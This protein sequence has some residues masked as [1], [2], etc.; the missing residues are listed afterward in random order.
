M[1]DRQ[2][3]STISRCSRKQIHEHV[4]RACVMLC[5]EPWVH[6]GSTLWFGV[7][8]YKSAKHDVLL[9]C[10]PGTHVDTHSQ[11]PTAQVQ[12][13]LSVCVCVCGEQNSNWQNGGRGRKWRWGMHKGRAQLLSQ[14]QFLISLKINVQYTGLFSCTWCCQMLKKEG[15]GHKKKKTFRNEVYTSFFFF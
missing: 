7:I 6:G 5:E 14:F 11:A 12:S 9:E 3:I 1:T 2:M 10:T 13:D 8:L 15:S 4:Q